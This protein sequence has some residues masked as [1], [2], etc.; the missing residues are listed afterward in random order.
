MKKR[1]NPNLCKIHRSYT[2]EEIAALFKVHKK[3][4]RNWI[5]NGLPVY[6]SARPLIVLGTDLRLF[7]RQ[8]RKANQQHCQL[9][10]LYCLKCR[11]PKKP[12]LGTAHFLQMPNGAGRAFATCNECGS[13]SNK[14]FSWRQLTIVSKAL[15]MDITDGTKTHKYER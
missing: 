6:D 1:L 3:T 14:Y 2:V 13:K 7:I 10:E 12:V 15:Q 4:V 8:Q 5:T 9:D 11:S